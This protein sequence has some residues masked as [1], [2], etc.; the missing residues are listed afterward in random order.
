MELRESIGFKDSLLGPIPT[1]WNIK[2]LGDI[3]DVKMCKRIF[4]YQTTTRGDV[5]FYKIGTFGKEPDAY[6]SKELFED[7]KKKYSFPKKGSLLISASG[8]IGRTVEYV[9]EDAYYQDSNIIWIENNEVLVTNK[10]LKHIFKIIKYNTEGSTIKRLYNSIVKS[11]SFALPPTLEEQK[12]IATTLSDVDELIN[13]LKKLISKKKNIK[14]GAM[15]QL[16]T[17][18]HEGGKRLPGFSGDWVEIN[19]GR[20]SIL[21]ARIGWQ[22][23]TTA[24]YLNSGE[25]NLITGTDFKDGYI[26]W[27]NCVYVEKDRFDQDKNIQVQANDVLVTKDGTIGKVAFVNEVYKPTTLNSGVFVIRPL[28]RA[29]ISRFFYFIL[30]SEYFELFLSKLAA[31]STISH[32]YQKDFIHFTFPAPPTLEEQQSISDI[33]SDMDLEITQLETKKEKY[34]AIKQGMMQELLTGKIR[35]V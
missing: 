33:L 20:S 8:T 12:S 9:G 14:Q 23:L 35:L 7:F 10:Y 17:P 31:G 18:P 25:Y 29:Y 5:P 22:G 11:S 21:K 19:L 30:M 26:D 32:L 6:I 15:Q 2:T 3:G 24:E 4:S 13:R 1:D 28:D 27:E 34:Q 16:L